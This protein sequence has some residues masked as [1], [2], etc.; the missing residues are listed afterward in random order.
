[1]EGIK[2]TV[3]ERDIVEL[4]HNLIY[5]YA[6]RKGLDLDEWYGKLA[7]LLCKS[8]KL[9]QP[10]RGSLSTYF[11]MRADTLVMLDH[12]MR[13]YHK[14]KANEFVEELDLEV[15]ELEVLD[16]SFDDLKEKK[17]LR[18]IMDCGNEEIIQ[19]RYEGY[20][21]EEIADKM[22]VTQPTISRLL[23]KTL[24]EYKKGCEMD[25]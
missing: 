19:L 12:K 23:E 21:Q 7:I 4:N 9:W 1:M 10:N 25:Y 15:L 6:N 2:L 20:T 13:N 24:L 17:I 11:Y 18:E 16:D 22:G 14:R 8:V 3:E 5:G